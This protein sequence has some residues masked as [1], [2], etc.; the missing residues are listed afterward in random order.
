MAADALFF[1]RDWK[2]VGNVARRADFIFPEYKVGMSGET[3]VTDIDGK[4]LRLAT[5][6]EAKTLSFKSSDSP[7]SFE[8]AFKAYH[9][10]LPWEPWF[11][12]LLTKGGYN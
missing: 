3:W 4:L 10:Q 8:K 9:G 12:E 6:E 1:G 11:T 7:I 5:W 2:V